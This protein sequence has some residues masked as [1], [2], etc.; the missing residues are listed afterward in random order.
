[1]IINVFVDVID[2]Q[3]AF[4]EFLPAGLDLCHEC[5]ILHE[6]LEHGWGGVGLAAV[7]DP[8]LD[9]VA[10]GKIAVSV[11]QVIV[12][13]SACMQFAASAVL[14]LLGLVEIGTALKAVGIEAELGMDYVVHE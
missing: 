6:A 5:G 10:V 2:A 13:D 8:G 9:V 11:G 4:T 3:D 7:I 14:I 1:M 12:P